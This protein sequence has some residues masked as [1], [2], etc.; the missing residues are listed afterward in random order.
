MNSRGQLLKNQNGR[1]GLK[2]VRVMESLDVR[3]SLATEQTSSDEACLAR[4][5]A[6]EQVSK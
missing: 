2:A 3:S 4:V 6:P 1:E 5:K